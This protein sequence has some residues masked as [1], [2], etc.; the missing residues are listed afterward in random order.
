MIFRDPS[1]VACTGCG[2]GFD[3]NADGLGE[4]LD[5]MTAAGWIVSTRTCLCPRCT[6]SDIPWFRVLVVAAIAGVLLVS[7]INH[8][9]WMAACQ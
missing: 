4:L 1:D 9:S 6:R 8:E 5:E 3:S 7:Q 2:H